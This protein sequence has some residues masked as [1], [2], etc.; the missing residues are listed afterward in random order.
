MTAPWSAR[1]GHYIWPAEMVERLTQLVKVGLSASQIGERLEVSRNAVIGK[2][3]RLG[4]KL[5]GNGQFRRSAKV[6]KVKVALSERAKEPG[7]AK[8]TRKAAPVPPPLMVVP[9]LPISNGHWKG[10]AAVVEALKAGECRWPIG[11]PGP[12]MSF[13]RAPVASRFTSYCAHHEYMSGKKP[14]AA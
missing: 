4:I 12:S 14:D 11:D 1:H 6:K 5:A 8:G 3:A 10:I 9:S 7:K 13:C 2:C